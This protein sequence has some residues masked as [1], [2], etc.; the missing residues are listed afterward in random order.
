MNDRDVEMMRLLEQNGGEMPCADLTAR[1][2]A[3]A[4]L[5]DQLRAMEARG[6]LKVDGQRCV[7]TDQGRTYMRH[8]E[9][10]EAG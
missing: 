9:H 10:V 7:I 8:H 2:G 4:E 6:L 5:D 3:G 1:F